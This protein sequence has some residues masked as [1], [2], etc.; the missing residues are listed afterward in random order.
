MVDWRIALLLFV[1]FVIVIAI[2]K[3]ISLGSIIIALL[4]PALIYAFYTSF[5]L[6]AIALLFTLIVLV[7]H[8]ENIKRLFKGTENKISFSNKKKR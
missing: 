4:Y 1:V 5:L 6:A 3:W 8:R 2:T 7:A